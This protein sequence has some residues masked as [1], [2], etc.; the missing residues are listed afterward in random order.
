ML[1]AF[2]NGV[3]EWVIAE[4]PE[5]ATKIILKTYEVPL[6]E[7]DTDWVECAPE[8][9]FTYNEDDGVTQTTK[10][11]REWIAQK[12]RGFLATTEY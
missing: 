1:K 5:E 11:F 2:K 7:V 10:P 6:D 3:I 4:T 12:G 9:L 8:K